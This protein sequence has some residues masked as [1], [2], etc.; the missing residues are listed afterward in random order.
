MN[1]LDLIEELYNIYLE[2]EE[3]PRIEVVEDGLDFGLT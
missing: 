1:W 3:L 2:K